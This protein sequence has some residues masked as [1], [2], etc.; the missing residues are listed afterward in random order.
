MSDKRPTRS[1]KSL[2]DIP[3]SQLELPRRI[4]TTPSGS[5][6]VPTRSRTGFGRSPSPQPRNP[7]AGLEREIFN[8]ETPPHRRGAASSVNMSSLPAPP[9]ADATIEEIRSYAEAMHQQATSLSSH[10]ATT[11]QLLTQ[12]LT[13]SS[14]AST[15]KPELPPFD[16]KNLEPWIRRTENA[17]VRANINEPKQKFAYLEGIIS[18]DLHPTVNAYFAGEATQQNY[19]DFLAFLRERYGRSKEQR[20]QSSIVGVRRN[21]RMPLDLAAVILEQTEGVTIDD[22]RK[23]HL[24]AE[25]PQQVRS[26]ISNRQDELD[27]MGLAKAAN[28]YFDRDGGL[29]ATNNINSINAVDTTPC[30]EGA[31]NP[32][33]TSN[34]SDNSTPF[35]APF[36][37]HN[38]INSVNRRAPSGNNSRSKG[39]YSSSRN[40]NSNYN[41][42]NNNDNRS[43]SHAQQ[44]QGS[45]NRT[46]SRPNRSSSR[47][48]NENPAHCWYHNH[49]GDK[50]TNCQQ[51]CSYAPNNSSR[52]G[53]GRG[54]RR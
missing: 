48:R 43:R 28:E 37:D 13:N 35:T 54:G 29:K 15:K 4:F 39:S 26:N 40:S 22:I 27:F 18:V 46:T 6:E 49:Y 8:F 17:F 47:P 21:G 33:A 32:S 19:D 7:T 3:L 38:G 9:A 42:N 5:I 53:N 11:S 50:A 1:N 24:L 25:L 45:A 16:P 41:N 12:S 51:P 34:L 10:L 44:G 14:R 30:P 23:A 52:S 31:S 20:V 2:V 36:D